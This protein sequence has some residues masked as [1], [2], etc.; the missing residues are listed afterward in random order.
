MY[1][2]TDK[3]AH[4][5][6]FLFVS[7]LGK[8]CDCSGKRALPYNYSGGIGDLIKIGPTLA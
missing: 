5:E 8:W 4:E 6:T 2:E 3:S 1:R 7:S